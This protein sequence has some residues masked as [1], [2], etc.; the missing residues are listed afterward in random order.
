MITLTSTAADQVKKILE[1]EN[2]AAGG[3]RIYVEGG[4]CSGLSYGMT[5]DE[6]GDGDEVFETAGVKVIIDP[7]SLERLDGAEVDYKNDLMGGGFAIKNPNAR[8]SCGCGHS[9][10]T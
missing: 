10:T 6:V 8:A 2:F 7:V 1:Q 3:L 5:L 4:G 9:F